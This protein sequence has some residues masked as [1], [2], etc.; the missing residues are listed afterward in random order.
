[1]DASVTTSP[2]EIQSIPTSRSS[3]LV[4]LKKHKWLALFIMFLITA[5]GV[6]MAML[7]G[8][9]TYT[10]MAV[11]LVSP[12]FI[13]NLDSEKGMDLDRTTYK[14]Y[15]ER[16]KRII[17]RQDVLKEVLQR[18]EIRAAWLRLDETEEL[19]LPRLA[20]ALTV[21]NSRG[22]P[23]ISVAILNDRGEGLKE[24]LNTV[25]EVYLRKS[26]E[27]NLYGSDERIAVLQQRRDELLELI[28]QRQK[29]KNQIAEELGVT[30]FNEGNLNPY[31]NILIESTQAQI[32]SRRQRVEAETRFRSLTEGKSGE[33]LLDTQVREMVAADSVLQNF[34][35]R[36]IEQKTTLLTQ[37]IGLTPQH[38]TRQRAEQEIAKIDR[39]IGQATASLSEEIRNRLLEQARAEVYKAQ[40]LEDALSLELKTQREQANHYS[41]LYNRALTF[42]REIERAYQQLDKI[43][44]RVD[45]LTIEASAPGFVRLDTPAG[46][47]MMSGGRKKILLIFI[48]MGLGLG[49]M[50]PFLVD[51]LDRR[52]RTPAEIHKLLGFAPMAWVLERDNPDTEQLALDYLRRLAL[53]LAREWQTNRTHYFVLTAVKPAGGTT[54][55]TLELARTLNELG[56]RTLA[57]ELNA[58]K[59]DL[60][61]QSTPPGRSGVATLLSPTAP[62]N[63][64]PETLIVPATAQLPARLPIGETPSRHLA[65]YG[66]LS[67]LLQQ[68]S[69][70]YDLILIDTPPVL[71]SAD[72]ELLAEIAGGVLLVVEAGHIT[73]AEL[74]RAAQSVERLNPPVVGVILNRLKVY[75]KDGYFA[76]QLKEYSTG[77]KLPPHWVKRWLWG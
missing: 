72:A 61:Y 20:S 28:S 49:I 35:T 15:I 8:K 56:I 57:M 73:P 22:S 36:L 45:F 23:F 30:T 16:Q 46:E 12:Q 21:G 3:P 1:M 25:V 5:I 39:D 33:T 29:I 62:K 44:Q 58:F 37:L 19:G 38:P 63:L 52:I 64:A 32:Q 66:K 17:T 7:L 69:T 31:D 77:A 27:E 48:V 75:P 74:K 71:L 42:S 40:Q 65:S 34:K 59:P 47:P 14:L 10:T 50:V 55:L 68:L 2:A 4:S 9:V 18:P 26:Q 76:E 53:A 67:P 54:T 43:D 11:I 41:T 13:P 6:P 51:L 70:K 60:R 24:V